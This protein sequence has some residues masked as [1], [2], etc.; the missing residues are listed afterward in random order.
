MVADKERVVKCGQ[1][2]D[3]VEARVL[4]LLDAG[5][6][7]LLCVVGVGIRRG[8]VFA[9]DLGIIADGRAIHDVDDEGIDLRGLGVGDVRV[10]IPQHVRVA[11]EIERV[12]VLGHDVFRE[13]RL[14]AGI[15]VEALAVTAAIAVL[16]S[17]MNHVG[18]EAV[19]DL[20][21]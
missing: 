9:E 13:A 20:H 10:D 4:D 11:R 5:L 7:F 6:V 18:S 1:A 2:P 19:V 16:A 15:I 3:H 12:D 8:R 14:L 21:G 17:R